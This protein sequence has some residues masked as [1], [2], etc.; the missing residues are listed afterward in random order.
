MPVRPWSLSSH[1]RSQA[2]YLGDQLTAN[3]TAW[4]K[5]DGAG[6]KKDLELPSQSNCVV[7]SQKFTQKSEWLQQ[8]FPLHT[9]SS[10]Y[11]NVVSKWNHQRSPKQT[12][13]RSTDCQ[14]N[15]LQSSRSSVKA[16]FE[17]KPSCHLILKS[18]PRSFF[19]FSASSR[20][21][22]HRGADL[23]WDVTDAEAPVSA[24]AMVNV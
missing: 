22:P 17:P 2:H 4:R 23:R 8:V 3:R 10:C 14:P 11:L 12:E 20:A 18:S 13:S 15:Q 9:R 6:V 16:S 5:Q 21:W 1:F 19:I 24:E 7:F